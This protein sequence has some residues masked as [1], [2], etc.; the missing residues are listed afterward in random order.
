MALWHPGHF[1]RFCPQHQ[2]FLTQDL[3]TYILSAIPIMDEQ[4]QTMT[5]VTQQQEVD[6]NYEAFKKIL[7]Q[8][9][10]SGDL[11]RFALMQNRE[12]MACFDTSRDA[13]LAG[14]KLLNGE[15][16]SVQ[17]VTD[18]PVDLGYYSHFKLLRAN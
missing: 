5:D 12:V 7:P 16:F 3:K 18:K 6:Q 15:P 2:H 9:M 1:N 10:E 4:V 11:N 13:M 8:L 17:E 14:R